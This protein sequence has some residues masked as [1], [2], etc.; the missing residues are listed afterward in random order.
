[1][2]VCKTYHAIK[3]MPKKHICGLS[4]PQGAT[5]DITQPHKYVCMC[6]YIYM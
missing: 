4:Y 2:C 3:K 6:I 5:A 1:M